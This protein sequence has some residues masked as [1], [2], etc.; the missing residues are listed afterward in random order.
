MAYQIGQHIFTGVKSDYIEE[1]SPQISYKDIGNSIQGDGDVA[2]NFS[3]KDIVLSTNSVLDRNSSYYLRV[4][5]PQDMNYALDFNVRLINNN[6]DSKDETYQF[7]KKINVPRGTSEDN[8]KNVYDVVL[9]EDENDEVK[10][11]IPKV[12]PASRDELEVGKLY[13]SFGTLG[14]Q[15]AFKVYKGYVSGR[16]V[17]FDVQNYNATTLLASWNQ[18]GDSKLSYFDI[19]FQ[20]VESFNAIWLYLIRTTEDYN[21]QGVYKEND[22]E[23]ITMGRIVDKDKVEVSLYKLKNLLSSDGKIGDKILSKIGVWSHPNLLMA[24][25]GEEIRVGASGYY[26]VDTL[27]IKTLG[28]KAENYEDNFTIDY[29]YDTDAVGA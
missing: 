23:Q 9:Y 17:F 5:I 27:P 29:T 13:V 24:V 25:N 7:L 21:I 26:E 19:V 28:I 8:V 18:Q 6:A 15:K 4:G 14:G 2:T 22:V 3:F 16:D 1:I 20:P 10:L 11:D 12:I